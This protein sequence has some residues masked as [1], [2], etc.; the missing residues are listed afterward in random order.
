MLEAED[1][2]LV[3]ALKPSLILKQLVASFRSF[4]PFS[5]GQPMAEAIG[6]DD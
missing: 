6:V 1:W 5:P 3:I 4:G 2:R